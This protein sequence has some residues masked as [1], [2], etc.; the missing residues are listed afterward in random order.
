[1]SLIFHFPLK[2]AK[3]A[4]KLT[5]EKIPFEDGTLKQVNRITD[6]MIDA[7]T[8][9]KIGEKTTTTVSDLPNAGNVLEESGSKSKQMRA[10]TPKQPKLREVMQRAM[11]K[12]RISG[13]RRESETAVENDK[14]ETVKPTIVV[15][16]TEKPQITV[17]EGKPVVRFKNFTSN[18]SALEEHNTTDIPDSSTIDAS[19]AD[20]YGRENALILF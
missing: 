8:G 18:L 15:E 10:A 12:V 14:N 6:A 2:E 19:L 17:E 5:G 1:M 13:G 16:E 9:Q 3:A 11:D 7:E 4:E 20:W